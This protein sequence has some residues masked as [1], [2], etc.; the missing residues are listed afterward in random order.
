MTN[1]HFILWTALD[2]SASLQERSYSVIHFGSKQYTVPI[3]GH[4]PLCNSSSDFKWKNLFMLLHQSLRNGFCPLKTPIFRNASK[5]E[6]SISSFSSCFFLLL[7]MRTYWKPSWEHPHSAFI[8]GL[9]RTTIWDWLS[10][11][12]KP[13]CNTVLKLIK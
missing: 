9:Y 3:L 5:N 7:R 12:K 4:V 11:E 8:T 2:S 1:F 10:I 6:S 13:C